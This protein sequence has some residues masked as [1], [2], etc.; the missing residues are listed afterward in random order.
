MMGRGWRM[1]Q[2]KSKTKEPQISKLVVFQSQLVYK[3]DLLQI[4]DRIHGHEWPTRIE[5]GEH[6][7]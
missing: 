1:Q 5:V 6:D 2:G 4:R 7:D 3:H